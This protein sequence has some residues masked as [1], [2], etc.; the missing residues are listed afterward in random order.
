[1]ENKVGAYKIEYETLKNFEH[2]N[3]SSGYSV[4]SQ[5]L[6]YAVNKL[7][8]DYKDDWMT[9]VNW[10]AI[11]VAGEDFYSYVPESRDGFHKADLF[12]AIYIIPLVLGCFI[13]CCSP[14][15]WEKVESSSGEIKTQL[16]KNKFGVYSDG[17]K[18]LKD[19]TVS[20]G[21]YYGYAKRGEDENYGF[22]G[23]VDAATYI[24]A[25]AK[26][27]NKRASLL[28]ATQDN[29]SDNNS[30]IF[31][32]G[33]GEAMKDVSDFNLPSAATMNDR[34]G[35]IVG[36]FNDTPPYGSDDDDSTPL[37]NNENDE[38]LEKAAIETE[39]LNGEIKNDDM[40]SCV[41]NEE[42]HDTR[43]VETLFKITRTG[44]PMPEIIGYNS[45]GDT[46]M[47][48]WNDGEKKGMT[49]D[50]SRR[51][52]KEKYSSVLYNYYEKYFLLYHVV[53]PGKKSSPP[54]ATPPPI[55]TQQ[56]QQS[57][58]P[59]LPPNVL[60]VDLREIYSFQIAV[61]GKKDHSVWL[62][63]I[64]NPDPNYAYYLEGSDDYY[65]HNFGKWHK[66]TLQSQPQ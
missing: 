25:M 45:H 12:P 57:A 23:W 53:N 44:R 55:N 15:F 66:V 47:C 32:N 1:M 52:L 35:D 9:D 18:C 59:A 14:A 11:S 51:V 61:L 27:V 46:F 24:I 19:K 42:G 4:G 39:L 31:I 41:I 17:S 20:Q 37:E 63:K 30:A 7:K 3:E 38:N 10:R 22:G 54:T 8:D 33:S 49:E 29:V 5:M 48:R 43:S 26:A 64:T 13:P 62:Y 65:W 34:S 21:R 28:M 40:Y 58:P 16:W 6:R 60:W 2:F 50:I 56:D 36:L